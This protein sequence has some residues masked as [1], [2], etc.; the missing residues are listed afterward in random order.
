V[1]ACIGLYGTIAYTVELP[2]TGEIGIRVAL[3]ARRSHVFGMVMRHVLA[4]APWD[5]R[6]VCR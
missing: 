5:S 3:G 2:C 1:I 4:M 6:S